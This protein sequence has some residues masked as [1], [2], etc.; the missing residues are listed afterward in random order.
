M[1]QVITN[2]FEQYWQSSLAAEQP[3]V[4]D[5]F[6]LANIPNLDI[7]SPIDPDT[8][9]PPESQIVH[10]QNVD[11][12][13][14][15]NNN[16]V[17]YTIV[18]DTTVGDFSFN[19]M[20]LRN[21][22]NGVIGMIVYKGRETK[23]KTDQ[24]TGQTGNSLVKSMLMGYDQAAEATLTNV[25]A[26]TW[27]IDYA[28]RLRGQDEDLR[29]L[30]SQLYGHHTFIGDGFK[31]VQQDGGHQVTPGVAIIGGL[32]VELKAPEVIYPG[33]KPIGVWVDVHRAGSLLSEH[34]N[35]FTI[36]TSVADLTDHVDSSGYQHFVAKLGTILADST[37]E[38]G[39]GSA[40]GGAGSIPDT[41]ALWKRSMAEA[42][43]DLI[44]QFGIRMT[45]ENA[46][47]V[48]LSKDGK[49][50]F[51][52]TGELPKD[53]KE[54]EYPLDGV[55]GWRRV[56]DDHLRD[57]LLSYD[58]VISAEPSWD[59]IP[60]HINRVFDSQSVAVANRIEYLRSS[61]VKS[62]IMKAG[63]FRL[64][65]DAVSMKTALLNNDGYYYTPIDG[66]LFVT[67]GS[68]PDEK[69]V[70]VG[71]L[72]EFPIDHVGNWMKDNGNHLAAFNAARDSK[73][74]RG[75]GLVYFSV[76][77]YVFD[78]EF[79]CVDFVKFKGEDRR[80]CR[81]F[82]AQGK[83]DG[84]AVVRACKSSVGSSDVP[85]YLSFSGF[86]NCT[87]DGNGSWD[88]GL[89]VRHCTNES[90]FD[91]V[92]VQRCKLFNSVFIGSFYGS[93]KNHVSRDALDRGCVIGLKPF[94][95]GGLN[96]VNAWAFN[97]LRGNYAGLSGK[98]HKDSNPYAGSCLTIWSANSCV[99][100][101]VGAEN[102]YGAGA[103]LRKGINSVISNLYLETNNKSEATGEKIGLR[104]IDADFPSLCIG[105]LN[106][107]RD[108][109]IILEGN[110]LLSVSELY[111]ESF[112]AGLFT[113]TG[114]ILLMSGR[115]V[116]KL[117]QADHNFVENI[118]TKR[119][120]Q[121]LNINF[122]SFSSL[123]DALMI[124]GEDMTDVQVVIVPRVSVTAAENVYIGLSSNLANGQELNFGKE[125]V[126]GTPVVK[127]F[128]SISKGVSRL[129]HRSNTLPPAASGFIVDIFVIQYV[130]DYRVVFN[131][132]F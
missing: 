52:W 22:Q 58:G 41:F 118:E 54:D 117:S 44:G 74:I 130:C 77:D 23:L 3:V 36:I 112:S 50:V 5:E 27:Q 92:S 122:T 109:K 20:Y 19:A 102:A 64:G 30:A 43:Y 69:W 6:I 128:Q 4:L 105:S 68:E 73:A 70:C 80:K 83:G 95:E 53:V 37:I 40:G 48:V 15:I 25:D 46:A 104:V 99:F 89:Y 10:R 107:T 123:N 119:V 87:I 14:R 116:N 84:K 21:K 79:V 1:S 111:S 47:Q 59:D 56:T 49:D 75:G 100:D 9:L 51:L 110:S 57:D 113:G 90:V 65:G 121:F 55:N 81:I 71:L 82:G 78:D 17:A 91:D 24:S 132:Q 38:D 13:G 45:I 114:K 26:G 96:E 61:S 60:S 33:S 32:R 88:V 12:R 108:Q 103:V 125:F 67:A 34:Q 101:Y 76:G 94:N 85:E 42:G 7:T 11:Q 97:N 16:A 8:S 28:A 2:A 129:T 127:R 72:N 66:E 29:Q 126:S 63:S 115:S 106:A 35:H 18:M 93:S 120:A 31:V 39:R 62:Q 131:K 124:F 98:Y 86:S